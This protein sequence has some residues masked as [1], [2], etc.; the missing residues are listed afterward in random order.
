MP[1]RTRNA[2]SH[3]RLGARPHSAENRPNRAKP[4]MYI[5]LRPGHLGE[6]RVDRQHRGEGEAVGDRDPAHLVQRGVERA[7]QRGEAELHDAGIDLSGEGAKAGDADHQPGI[8]GEP[9][10]R[11][12]RGRFRQQRAVAVFCCR[13]SVGNHSGLLSDR[14]AARVAQQT[15]FLA[16]IR[17]VQHIAPHRPSMIRAEA[18]YDCAGKRQLIIGRTGTALS[19][20]Q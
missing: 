18:P 3:G 12:N 1:C 2:I 19:N 8:G 7:L 9:G 10:Q 6:A 15:R 4:R 14:K 5:S 11:V 13:G 17:H 20:R 16:W